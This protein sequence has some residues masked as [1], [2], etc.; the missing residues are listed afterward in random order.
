[1]ST[2]FNLG[3]IVQQEVRELIEQRKFADLKQV[4]AEWSAGDLA[5]LM[6]GL[7]SEDRGIIFRILPRDLAARTFD[8]LELEDQQR[9]L[10]TL[11]QDQ[12]VEIL[13]SMSPDDRTALLE[14][15]PSAATKKLI[16]LLS[17]SERKVA[18][19]LLGYPEG[20]IGRLMTPDYLSVQP[21]WT[22]AQSLDYIRVHGKDRETLSIIYVLDDEGRLIDDIRAQQFLLA[23]LDHKV[24][25]M[26][27]QRFVSLYAGNAREEAVRFFRET[28]LYA[29]PVTDS[30]GKL[31]GIVTMDDVLDV[32]EESATEDIQKLGGSEALNAPYLSIG[33]F[34]MIKKRAGWLVILF[35]G[36]MLTATAMGYFQD[37]IS[38]AVVL[39]L[40]I[41][42]IISSGGN[43]GSQASTLIIR[44]LALGEL[45]LGNWWLIMRR[46]LGVGLAMGGILGVIGFLRI[47]VWSFFS[48]IYGP[49]WFLVGLTV[50]FS[51]VGVV[52]WG[53]FSGSMLPLILRKC[54]MDP[55]T[56]SAPFVATLVDVTGLI[57]YF[58]IAFLIL[59]GTLL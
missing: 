59:K 46:E 52:M 42:L 19:T 38:K 58:G 53:A 20:S 50:A 5:S 47:A 24:E 23:P 29:L 55:A 44:A 17:P 33:F 51:L 9:L 56:S 45:S 13:N 10:E 18:Q 35:I 32:A 14:E 3:P 48:P 16:S 25:E 41:P 12:V 26:M 30:E 37:E 15:L 27:D 2:L 43:S 54:R 49:H 21:G 22:V 57:I 1:M 28:D 6:R 11:G 31:I 36:E 8:Y 34:E 39:A 4:F 7:E 40:F